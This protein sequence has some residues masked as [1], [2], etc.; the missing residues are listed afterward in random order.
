M[1]NIDHVPNELLEYIFYYVDQASLRSQCIQVS[2]NWKQIIH[3][4]EFWK[5]Y[6]RFWCNSKPKKASN[7]ESGEKNIDQSDSADSIP[8]DW[9]FYSHLNPRT[10]PFKTNLLRNPDGLLVTPE[11]LHSQDNRYYEG[12]S[13]FLRTTYTYMR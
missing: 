13:L 12:K 4:V 9:V 3:S 5:D 7:T 1:C 11:E 10:N 6:H 2:S 8:Y